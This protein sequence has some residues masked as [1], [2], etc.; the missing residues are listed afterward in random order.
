MKPGVSRKKPNSHAR[1]IPKDNSFPV[2]AIGASAG[3]LEAVTQL[4]QNLP[5]NTGMAFIY[6]QHL[7][8][9][10]KSILTSILGK[11]TLMNVLEVTNRILIKPD[12]FYVI[13]PDKEMAVLDGHIK[14]KPRR[15]DRIANLPV[16]T[17]FCSLAETHKQGA[18]GIILSGSASD[19]TRG[20]S[21]IKEAGGLTFAVCQ[22][23]PLQPVQWILF[24]RPKKLPAN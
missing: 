1:S 8:P 3:G 5:P 7:S 17:F 20:L 9:D 14:L 11:V 21:A 13:P 16:D 2:V 19:G 12:H 6:V 23:P 15:K 24:Y 18:I 4:L 10:H 22:N